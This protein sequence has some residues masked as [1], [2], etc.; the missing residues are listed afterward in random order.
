MEQQVLVCISKTQ[1]VSLSRYSD[2]KREMTELDYEL[3]LSQFCT[4]SDTKWR[5][6]DKLPIELI[7]YYFY[8]SEVTTKF[9]PT[10]AS[11]CTIRLQQKLL[12]NIHYAY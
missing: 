9:V 10:Y 6:H 3:G 2:D 12:Q 4:L 8:R 1:E 7:D 11:L 5:L